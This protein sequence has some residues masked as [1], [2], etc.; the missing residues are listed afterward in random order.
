MVARLMLYVSRDHYEAGIAM[1]TYSQLRVSRAMTRRSIALRGRYSARGRI[2][3]AV[4]P[5]V[6][7][8][9]AHADQLLESARA[10]GVIRNDAVLRQFE[11]I[12]GARF[13]SATLVCLLA[14]P[15]MADAPRDRVSA[16]PADP[17]IRCLARIIA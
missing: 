10:R 5:I 14:S 11:S 13:A 12:V 7:P 1:Q 2:E 16:R 6:T 8:S 17:T 9:V 15:P 4:D 3:H